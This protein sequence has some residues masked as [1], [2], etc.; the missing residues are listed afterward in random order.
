MND[1]FVSNNEFL[2]YAKKDQF[3]TCKKLLEDGFYQHRLVNGQPL[4]FIVFKMGRFS[5]AE[6][7]MDFGASFIEISNLDMTKLLKSLLSRCKFRIFRRVL[8]SAYSEGF[9][10]F[11][12]SC[13]TPILYDAYVKRSS[14]I[15]SELIKI[16]ARLEIPWE[17][18]MTTP[19]MWCHFDPAILNLL[20]SSGISVNAVSSEGDTAL[21]CSVTRGDAY[22]AVRLLE[23]GANPN[24]KPKNLDC[25]LSIACRN[26]SRGTSSF[27]LCEMLIKYG[28]DTNGVVWF[29]SSHGDNE[30]KGMTPLQVAVQ[31]KNVE[32][33]KFL[34]AKG[35]VGE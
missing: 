32:L 34:K 12:E 26:Y 22:T 31:E 27:F 7:L 19:L 23:K 21:S 2:E 13:L 10:F 24:H 35:A 30:K 25:I 6:L 1:R 3:E 5:I 28:A 33:E 9:F 18:N 4:V 20:L 17:Y 11:N 29:S 15:V 8:Q 14:A 16:G